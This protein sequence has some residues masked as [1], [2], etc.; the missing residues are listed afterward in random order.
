[1]TKMENEFTQRKDDGRISE[2]LLKVSS[3]QQTIDETIKP[4][5]QCIKQKIYGN[6]K[7]GC[8]EEH[9][10]NMQ[11]I[12]QLEKSKAILQ[13]G[14]WAIFILVLGLIAEQVLTKIM[15]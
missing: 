14:L 11:K 15:K 3:L 2:I 12:E 10:V 6:G 8:I 5:I 7:N 9:I 4:D 13:K 1:M